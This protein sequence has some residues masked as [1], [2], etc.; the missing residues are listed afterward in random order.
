MH[1]HCSHATSASCCNSETCFLG[2][3]HASMCSSVVFCLLLLY[4][5]SCSIDHTFTPASF[6][7]V[8]C[9]RASS[10]RRVRSLYCQI[11]RQRGNL[12]RCLVASA[13]AR[14]KY[15]RTMHIGYKQNKHDSLCSLCFCIRTMFETFNSTPSTRCACQVSISPHCDSLCALHSGHCSTVIHT[16][17]RY[18]HYSF[19]KLRLHP[20]IFIHKTHTCMQGAIVAR[21][22]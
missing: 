14:S 16:I 21:S 22:L 19:A 18:Q 8:E 2:A 4:W 17:K 3:K 5:C 15:H 6:L 10:G 7:Q 11:Q 20:S 13:N 9:G 12:A 1:N